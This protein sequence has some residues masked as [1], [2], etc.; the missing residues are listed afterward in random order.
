MGLATPVINPCSCDLNHD[1]W[2]DMRDW[3]LF[4]RQWGHTDCDSVYCPCDLNTDGRCDMRDWLLFGRSWGRT[5]CP[6]D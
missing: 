6:V 1:G 3:L 5:D 4:G 2:C